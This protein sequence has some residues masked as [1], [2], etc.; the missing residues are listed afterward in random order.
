[1]WPI[2]M[3]H[4]ANT[5]WFPLAWFLLKVV[6]FL[7]VFIWLRGTLPRVRYDQFMKLGWKVL[8]PVSMVWLMLVAA[9]RAMRNENY[10]FTKIVLYIGGA[11]VALLLVSLIADVFRD[12]GESKTAEGGA[13][14]PPERFDPM[15]GGYP[16]P[17]LPGQQLQGVPRRPS[18]A[19]AQLVG[20]A[21]A[22]GTVGAPGP[23]APETEKKED[24]DA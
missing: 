5:G 6:G 13:L 23:E 4:G 21:G 10:D 3:W 11:V 9:V 7:F 22:S 16:V 17:P 20:A 24:D 18:R 19:Q 15:A 1:P 12:R 8:I 2:S 14:A